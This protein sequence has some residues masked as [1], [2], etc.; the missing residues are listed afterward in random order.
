MQAR[1]IRDVCVLWFYGRCRHIENDKRLGGGACIDTL[2]DSTLETY[3][4][5]FIARQ[6]YGQKCRTIIIII[7]SY[8]TW[9]NWQLEINQ[10]YHSETRQLQED[11]IWATGGIP[12]LVHGTLLG[13]SRPTII[14]CNPR[15][16]EY[17]Y[18]PPVD[19]RGYWREPARCPRVFQMLPYSC[20]VQIKHHLPVSGVLK[21]LCVITI[22]CRSTALSA[23]FFWIQQT[24][25]QILLLPFFKCARL[26]TTNAII[27]PPWTL[28]S[29]WISDLKLTQNVGVPNWN[30][31]II[32]ISKL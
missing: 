17:L 16:R 20:L 30:V 28:F 15:V 7:H 25:L 26:K 22:C 4:S 9:H 14:H 27:Y 11:S 24:F 31:V 18:P 12:Q 8:F 5:N 23:S 10:I 2:C 3:Y 1:S 32:F 19:A 29:L 6:L 13:T 21:L